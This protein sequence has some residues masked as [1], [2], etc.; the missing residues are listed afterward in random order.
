YEDSQTV[1][2]EVTK[3]G[4]QFPI[5]LDTQGNLSTKFNVSGT[6]TILLL[7]KDRTIS[8]LST[9]L[10]PTLELRIKNFLTN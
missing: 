8:W 10:S 2:S 4:Y 9:G 5:G 7:T 6:P 1:S 3:R